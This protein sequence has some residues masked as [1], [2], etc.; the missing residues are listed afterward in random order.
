MRAHVRTLINGLGR[1]SVV[2]SYSLRGVYA[3]VA[4]MHAENE[5]Y[6][7]RSVLVFA[8]GCDI[9]ELERKVLLPLRR[10]AMLDLGDAY[11]SR[12][13]AVSRKRLVR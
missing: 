8:L 10:E 13:I 3:M 6:L 9:D 5:L 12:V 7:S 11:V 4:A 1:N 2:R